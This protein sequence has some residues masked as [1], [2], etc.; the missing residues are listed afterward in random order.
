VKALKTVF[1]TAFSKDWM[2]TQHGAPHERGFSGQCNM[3]KIM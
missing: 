3:G 2:R 1:E